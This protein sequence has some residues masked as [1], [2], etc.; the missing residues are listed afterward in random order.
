MHDDDEFDDPT[1]RA[2]PECGAL[3]PSDD[4]E[5]P[6]CGWEICEDVEE[7]P[8]KRVRDCVVLPR[9]DWTDG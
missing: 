3:M 4:D 7:K 6:S 2:C 8:A 9:S 5:C 1:I